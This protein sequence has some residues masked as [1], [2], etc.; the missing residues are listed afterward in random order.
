MERALGQSS[1]ISHGP[2]VA[3]ALHR[4]PLHGSRPAHRQQ[5]VGLECIR[6]ASVPPRSYA[7][8]RRKS[9]R[10]IPR[11]PRIPPCQGQAP[12]SAIYHQSHDHRGSP[13]P[14]RRPAR[15]RGSREEGARGRPHSRSQ[16]DGRPPRK[17]APSSPN[18]S[19]VPLDASRLPSFSHL[20]I[21]LGVVPLLGE[22]VTLSVDI[23][24]PDPA[25]DCCPRRASSSVVLSKAQSTK[26]YSPYGVHD[27]SSLYP[28]SVLGDRILVDCSS[29]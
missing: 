11:I 20:P 1:T 25:Q 19:T 28:H 6:A 22:P 17:R 21:P 14:I 9:R 29:L 3:L 8:T 13:C 26:G 4:E 10:D 18:H 12:V 7:H 24:E 5:F 15:P 27:A 2:W 16:F 23:R